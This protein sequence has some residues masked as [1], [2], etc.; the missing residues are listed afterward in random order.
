MAQTRLQKPS[1]KRV[2]K[3]RTP[4]LRIEFAG[5]PVALFARDHQTAVLTAIKHHRAGLSPA[6]S[7]IRSAIVG[8]YRIHGRM[9]TFT[10]EVSKGLTRI[11]FA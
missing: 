5:A 4:K 11:A 7:G 6:P 3:R 1:K 10:T 8:L 2:S 9:L